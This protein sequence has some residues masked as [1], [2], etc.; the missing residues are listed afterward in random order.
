MLYYQNLLNSIQKSQSTLQ[1]W[2]NKIG[3]EILSSKNQLQGLDNSY[4]SL[5][6]Q[7]E[8]LSEVPI[9]TEINSEFIKKICSEAKYNEKY[10]F[11]NKKLLL[12]KL[13]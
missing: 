4:E 7:N 6:N 5:I 13:I 11:F 10:T 2:K 3:S 9:F 1:F 8:T 12:L